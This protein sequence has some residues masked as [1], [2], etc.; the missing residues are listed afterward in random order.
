MGHN[1]VGRGCNGAGRSR[2]EEDPSWKAHVG[3]SHLAAPP[4]PPSSPKTCTENIADA[5]PRRPIAGWEAYKGVRGC[6]S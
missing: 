5:V 6:E 1:W 2:E 3:S 4:T